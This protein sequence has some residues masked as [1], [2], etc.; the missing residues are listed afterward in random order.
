MFYGIYLYS[1]AVDTRHVLKITVKDDYYT[2][3][4]PEV[5]QGPDMNKVE[6]T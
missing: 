6:Y 5:F 4:M 2:E 1:V 3:Q